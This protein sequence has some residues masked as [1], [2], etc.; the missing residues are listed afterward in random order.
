MPLIS[1]ITP[2]FNHGLF[3]DE[4]FDSIKLHLYPNVFEHIIIDDGSTDK[5]T[6][7]KIKEL[8]DKGSIVIE[9][10]N[11]G[12]GAA[13]NAGIERSK[14]KYILPLDSDNKIIPDVFLRAAE[15][16]ESN[17]NV[18]AVYT[19]AVYF[20]ERS[21][22]WKT[23][24]I[25]MFRMLSENSIDACALIR[26][27]D[28]LQVGCYEVNMPHMGNEDWELWINLMSHQKK[29]YYLKEV[30]FYYRVLT[31][32]MLKTHTIPGNTANKIFIYKK[33][34]EFVIN[35]YEQLFEKS[36]IC[37]TKFQDFKSM[38]YNERL[39]SALKILVGR[40]FY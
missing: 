29:I 38:L 34:A 30:G 7:Q 19:D 20:G 24:D 8:S 39:Y 9:Q 16:L 37:E 32:S 3:L 31:N 12:L 21:G 6:K 23:G 33:H 28:I 15:Y 22:L 36:I 11:N 17:P 26:K 27:K 13:R 1:I 35:C 18:S 14:G 4:M 5:Y 25:D 10:K 40:K 2:C